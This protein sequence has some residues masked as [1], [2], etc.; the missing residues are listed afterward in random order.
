MALGNTSA[1]QFGQTVADLMEKPRS[2]FSEEEGQAKL[3]SDLSQQLS[4]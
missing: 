1:Y 2:S 3:H 4:R